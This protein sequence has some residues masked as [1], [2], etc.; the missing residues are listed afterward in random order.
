MGAGR[1]AGRIDRDLFLLVV[2]YRAGTS[3]VPAPLPYPIN[4]TNR[5]APVPRF[6]RA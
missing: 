1:N 6:E 5:L 2:T 3:D 4:I